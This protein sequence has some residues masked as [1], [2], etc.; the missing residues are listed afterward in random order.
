MTALALGAGGCA[1]HGLIASSDRVLARTCVSQWARVDGSRGWPPGV[2]TQWS[3]VE[4]KF[5]S[6]YHE[7]LPGRIRVSEFT[8]A[9]TDAAHS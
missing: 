1:R 3:A 7:P 9:C 6:L 8:R 2:D 5:A 4:A